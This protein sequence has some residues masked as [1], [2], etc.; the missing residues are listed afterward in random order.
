[1]SRERKIIY[2]VLEWSNESHGP[3]ETTI[4]KLFSTIKSAHDYV[5]LYYNSIKN[6]SNNCVYYLND[7]NPKIEGKEYYNLGF[8]SEDI[9]N[10][11]LFNRVWIESTYLD[12]DM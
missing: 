5:R 1:M 7:Y 3:N 12:E 2:L 6:F 8:Q 4:P 10:N 9:K 11:K